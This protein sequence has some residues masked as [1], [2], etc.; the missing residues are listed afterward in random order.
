MELHTGAVE[1][2]RT[3]GVVAGVLGSGVADG[4]V[5]RRV[6]R[7]LDHLRLYGQSAPRVVQLSFLVIPEHVERHLEGMLH[8]ALQRHSAP[9]LHVAVLVAQYL[10]L[11]HCG[12]PGCVLALSFF[13]TPK[14]CV[15]SL[16]VF[17]L[18]IKKQFWVVE[19]FEWT[20][21]ILKKIWFR[22]CWKIFSLFFVKLSKLFFIANFGN[23]KKN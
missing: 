18:V 8:D 15:R 21:V 14:F 2:A 13:Q 5:A 6:V 3:A 16:F 17:T 22:I 9:Y 4:Q 20:C 11:W 10:D 7:A 19:T 12:R 23:L 1:V